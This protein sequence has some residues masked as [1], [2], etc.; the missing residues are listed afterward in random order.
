M[1]HK[2]RAYLAVADNMSR[3][4]AHEYAQ[5]HDFEIVGQSGYVDEASAQIAQQNVDV[6]IFSQKLI[7]GDIKSLFSSLPSNIRSKC[8]FY[9]V[10]PIGCKAFKLKQISPSGVYTKRDAVESVLDYMNIP[11]ARKG[12]PLLKQALDIAISSPDALFEITE[13]VY[14]RIA[15]TNN[16]PSNIVEY[17]MR[18][19]KDYSM[20]HCKPDVIY[21]I[22]G[23]YP[24]GEKPSLSVYL[25]MLSAY[26]LRT[27]SGV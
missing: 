19:V 24:N 2:T 27:K 7:D 8:S 15:V 18:S 11:K 23:D 17:N 3:V 5:E 26:I 21:E 12:Y 1:K 9:M 25:S 13:K 22:F 6:V 4:R 16:I 10:C 14:K 20:L